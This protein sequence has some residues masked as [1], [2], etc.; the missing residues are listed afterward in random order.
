MCL[1]P[2]LRKG[3]LLD[4][5]SP[6]HKCNSEHWEAF[7]KFTNWVWEHM[8]WCQQGNPERQL[9]DKLCKYL[10]NHCCCSTVPSWSEELMSAQFSC[11]CYTS[12]ATSY[13]ADLKSIGNNFK[14]MLPKFRSKVLRIRGTFKL[15]GQPNFGNAKILRAPIVHTSLNLVNIANHMDLDLL[16]PFGFICNCAQSYCVLAMLSEWKRRL[17]STLR[18]YEMAAAKHLRGNA[19]HESQ[20]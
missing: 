14:Q 4:A 20:S 17:P 2:S 15:C 7:F 12:L 3:P 13:K 8:K 18:C 6:K 19:W 10:W 5:Y 16:I 1:L 9:D 11:C